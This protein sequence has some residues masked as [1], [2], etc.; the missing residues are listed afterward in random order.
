YAAMEREA[1]QSMAE[2]QTYIKTLE[3]RIEWLE[4]ELQALKQSTSWKLTGPLRR[5][6]RRLGPGAQT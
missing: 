1:E 2:C 4:N 5:L 3:D 6:R